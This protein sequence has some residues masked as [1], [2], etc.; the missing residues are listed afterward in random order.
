MLKT[1]QWHDIFKGLRSY[2]PPS[3]VLGL[4]SNLRPVPD[5]QL[6]LMRRY[7]IISCIAFSRKVL[8]ANAKDERNVWG[9]G[10]KYIRGP[11]VVQE[12]IYTCF[13]FQKGVKWRDTVLANPET[14]S[15]QVNT[16]PHDLRLVGEKLNVLCYIP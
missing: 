8:C 12:N 10:E 5:R 15:C 9:N 4:G 7:C 1:L 3:L 16:M 6:S 2:I 14:L 13:S 11:I